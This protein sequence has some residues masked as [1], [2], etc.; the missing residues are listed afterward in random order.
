MP[1]PLPQ[2]G[3]VLERGRP[4]QTW[5]EREAQEASAQTSAAAAFEALVEAYVTES[6]EHARCWAPV[7]A[8]EARAHRVSETAILLEEG[9]QR[10]RLICAADQQIVLTRE[11]ELTAREATRLRPAFTALADQIATTASNMGTSDVDPIWRSL[12]LGGRPVWA[13]RL[14]RLSA[15][16]AVM[17]L[18][19]KAGDVGSSVE[20]PGDA[21][22]ESFGLRLPASEIAALA[23]RLRAQRLVEFRRPL[24]RWRRRSPR[25]RSAGAWRRSP[26]I[27]RS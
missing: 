25:A 13:V 3:F 2:I 21:L 5:E 1:M 26:A 20:E 15:A 6:L 23:E 4:S 9:H 19:L 16:A 18:L 8:A 12:T 17:W 7:I 14:G 11:L 22:A 24:R 10:D 27:V